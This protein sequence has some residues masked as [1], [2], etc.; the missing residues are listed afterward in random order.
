MGEK[1]LGLPSII[2]TGVGLIV[3][4]SCLLSIDQG[5]AAVGTPFILTMVIACAFNI[6]TA[7]SIC[8]FN[9]LMPNLTGGMAQY[10]LACL[11]PFVSI[12]ITVGGYLTCQTIMGSSEAAMFG[13]TLSNV[14]PDVPISGS[15]YSI[16]LIVILAV[17]NLFGVDMF[18]KIQNIVAYGLIGSLIF[19]GIAGALGLGT[20]EVVEQEAVISSKPGDVLSLLGLAFFLFIGVE[21][22]VPISSQVKDARRKVPLG[23]VISLV[24]ILVM[25]IFMTIGFSRYTP[26]EDLGASTVPHILY[27]T[28]LYGKVGTIWMTIISLLAVISTLNTAMFSI[29]QICSGM[30]KIKL[31]PTVFLCRNKRG[32]PY[33]GLLLVA[34]IMIVINA[35]G[36]STSDQL[37]F[38]ILTGC[39]FWIFSYIIL[40][41]DVLV[42]RKRL[43]KAPRTFKLPL[44]PVIP[45][46]G[47]IGNAFM[48]YNIDPSWEIKK[49]IYLIF[50]IVLAVLSVYAVVW[51]KMVMKRPM[52][53]AFQIKEVMAME[54]DLYQ[55]HHNPKL[56]KRLRLQAEP[57]VQSVPADVNT[58]TRPE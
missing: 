55:M 58:G 50:V 6:L 2:A 4:T 17:L 30:A 19:L 40:H 3:A 43:P 12:V 36:L 35:T 54:S 25:Q 51:I 21:F 37:T 47:V 14:L 32:T 11:G 44:G 45:I 5:A 42:L 24:A 31:L 46:L 53:K 57:E 52:F 8:E 13:N 15:V 7:L 38:L 33:V 34:A 48:I 26:W 39:T 27:G 28:L 20:G 23:M 9:A 56:A 1:K 49:R 41:V 29:S 22:I 16:A 10:T 18:A